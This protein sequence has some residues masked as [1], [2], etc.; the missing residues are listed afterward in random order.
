[1]AALWSTLWPGLGQLYLGRR[2]AAAV[3]GLPL[4][5]LAVFV[6]WRALPGVD[7]LA[8]QIFQP[9]IALVVIALT[10]AFCALR[11]LAMIDAFARGTVRV[12]EAGS[13]AIRFESPWHSRR[14]VVILA[15]VVAIVLLAHGLVVWGAYS[16]YDA[17]SSIFV[18]SNPTQPSGTSPSDPQGVG[19]LPT[20]YATPA[21][22]LSRINALLIGADSGMGYQHSLTDTMIVVSVDPVS[23]QTVMLSFPRDLSRF[24]M[25]NGGTYPGKM[26]SLVNAALADPRHYPDG[27]IG[28]LT[29]EIGFLLGVP[30]HYYAFVN[31]AG[32][33][34]MIDVVG[35]VDV[36][37][38]RDIADPVYQ[39]PDGHVGFS[40]SAGSHH[41][42]GRT[43]LAYVRSRL[44]AG[45]NDF[46]RA[47]R[48]QELLVALRSK[49]TQP[50][51]IPNLPALLK[52]LSQTIQTDYPVGQLSAGL[53][54]AKEIDGGAIDHI[55]LGPPYAR[56]PPPN[57][58]GGVYMLV[59]DMKRM[60]RLSL[61]LFG[62]DSAYQ[63]VTSAGSPAP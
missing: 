56:N 7:L 63:N 6:G 27:G 4:L 1:M 38:P 20:P 23:K 16:F 36:V 22:P 31:L 28:T 14:A 11:L 40:L 9:G 12:R 54:L 2:R 13:Q 15:G 3:L 35:G 8:V 29:R 61:K 42:D 39:F 21:T 52:A 19:P 25:Y 55:V 24:Q 59:M 41:L 10:I 50:S 30:I 17:G 51:V 45:D 26:N 49:L 46:T 18:G 37:N 43:A 57:Q 33:K 32:F 60:A 47:G 44:G 5:A 48:Q 58:S 62:S 53:S 34:T